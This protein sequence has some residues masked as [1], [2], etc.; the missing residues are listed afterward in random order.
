M[1][2]R[3]F[4]DSGNRDQPPTPLTEAEWFRFRRWIGQDVRAHQRDQLR[5]L[6]L[7]SG[8]DLVLIA[9]NL[10]SLNDD[11][12]FLAQRAWNELDFYTAQ[13]GE[14]EATLQVFARALAAGGIVVESTGD[15][16]LD[17]SVRVKML[18]PAIVDLLARKT[19]AALDA[20]WIP[21]RVVTW[22]RQI[23]G[24][25]LRSLGVDQSQVITTA[26]ES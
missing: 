5:R 1:S 4:Q 10:N 17:L 11:L 24:G 21:A 8:D 25:W 26:E 6:P 13:P 14:L 3:L 9:A 22:L 23:A 12:L 19:P 18:I 16:Q 7:H 20:H 2:Q 15:E